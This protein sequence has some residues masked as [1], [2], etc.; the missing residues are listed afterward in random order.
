[1]KN[2]ATALR[3]VATVTGIP[4]ADA[5]ELLN[6]A[7]GHVKLAV[8]MQLRGVEAEDAKRILEASGGV[9]RVAINDA[10]G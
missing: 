1:M 3:I 8:V 5:S 9:L 4:P 10:T 6:R 7:G 2:C